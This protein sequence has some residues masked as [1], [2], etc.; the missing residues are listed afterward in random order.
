MHQEIFQKIEDE[1]DVGYSVRNT[2]TP[3]DKELQEQLGICFT[4]QSS[5]KG[6]IKFHLKKYTGWELFIEHYHAVFGDLLSNDE[7]AELLRQ[8]INE[9]DRENTFEY[10]H[11]AREIGPKP[12]VDEDF[13]GAHAI[14]KYT[15]IDGGRIIINVKVDYSNPANPEIEG[16][17]PKDQTENLLEI[18]S[19]PAAVN[20][21]FDGIA[22]AV[23]D[24][25]NTLREIDCTMKRIQHAVPNT[26]QVLLSSQKGLHQDH[27]ALQKD[28]E[29]YFNEIDTSIKASTLQLSSELD[30]V[31][32]TQRQHL[33]IDKTLAESA[34]YFLQNQGIIIKRQDLLKTKINTLNEFNDASFGFIQEDLTKGLEDVNKNIFNA[35]NKILEKIEAKGDELADKIDSVQ[36]LLK[37]ELNTHRQEYLNRL[38]VVVET[39]NRLPQRTSKQLIKDLT[40]MLDVS[41]STIYRYF[42]KL[43][44]KDLIKTHDLK[45]TQGPGRPSRFYLLTKKFK[46]I[47]RKIKECFSPSLTSSSEGTEKKDNYLSSDESSEYSSSEHSTSSHSKHF[48][49]NKDNKNNTY[50]NKR[51]EK[52]R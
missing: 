1:F 25:R 38:T 52:N 7:Q 49:K 20:K 51:Q 10:V 12:V 24:N 29:F 30:T 40:E 16:E 11:V 28:Q 22:T 33:E 43:R 37:R 13:K 15:S 48:K 3:I 46:E 5:R 32:N 35:Q 17:G 9:K 39:I 47:L 31:K 50:K 18:V 4:M 41:K 14:I 6:Y 45:I 19:R 23:I 44:E 8:M 2:A 26:G 36:A 27:L 42:R 21:T 34:R